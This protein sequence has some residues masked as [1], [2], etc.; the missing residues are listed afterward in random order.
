MALVR[1]DVS[2]ENIS[3]TTRVERISEVGSKLA[4]TRR[5]TFLRKVG[6]YWSHT[7]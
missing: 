5:D 4:V 3:Y 2:E 7:A 6:S 1:T